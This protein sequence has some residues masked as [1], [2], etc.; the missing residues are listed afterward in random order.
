[1]KTKRGFTIVELLTVL[2][3]ISILM[4]LL[5]PAIKMVRNMA[6]ETKARAQMSALSMGITAFRNDYGD[7]PPSEW[8][9]IND[10]GYCGAQKLAEALLGLDLMGFHP[11]SAWRSDGDQG[12]NPIYD[13]TD[14]NNLKQRRE[15]Y[16]ELEGANVYRLKEIFNDT[17]DLANTFVICDP[18][19]VRNNTDNP[20]AGK[21]GTPILYYKANPSSKSVSTTYGVTERI[22]NAEDN[23]SLVLLNRVTPTGDPGG[24]HQSNGNLFLDESNSNY[25]Y[26]Y[27]SYIRDP[28]VSTVNWPY[29]PDSYLLISAGLDGIYGTNDDITNFG[30]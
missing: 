19:G 14:E 11:N 16:I 5:L 22:Y 6:K 1:M 13:S 25:T 9:P 30:N 10:V 2:V 23:L 8:N 12:T 17:D 7:Y 3:I 24:K 26:F 27:E 29:R 20:K 4:G 28:K 18:F 21:I 15:R